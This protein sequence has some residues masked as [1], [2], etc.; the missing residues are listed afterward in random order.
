MSNISTVYVSEK[1]VYQN[2]DDGFYFKQ[3]SDRIEGRG[4]GSRTTLKNQSGRDDTPKVSP[5]SWGTPRHGI[6]VF[7]AARLRS[8][9]VHPAW[10]RPRRPARNYDSQKAV[11]VEE[12]RAQA[13]GRAL[14]ATVLGVPSVVCPAAPAIRSENAAPSSPLVP[15]AGRGN[16]APTP[17]GRVGAGCRA[18]GT[19]AAGAAGGA[20]RVSRGWRERW[21]N[22][23][24]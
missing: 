4:S 15:G 2:R 11:R 9:P 20:R 24:A 21:S 12:G 13:A 6:A 23:T 19:E 8:P 10:L 1:Q 7:C 3:E 14:E 17:A 5:G 22:S 16:P 18:P